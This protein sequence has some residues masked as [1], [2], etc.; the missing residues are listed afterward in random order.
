MTK[1]NFVGALNGHRNITTTA[2][3][4]AEPPKKKKKL[5]IVILKMRHERKIRKLEKAIRKLKKTPKQLKP[6]DEYALPPAVLKEIHIRTRKEEDPDSEFRKLS[7][8]WMTYRREEGRRER[9]CI[10]RVSAAKDQALQVLKMESLSL[11]EKA[12]D[13][14]H[15]LLPFQDNSVI[16]ETPLNPEYTPPDGVKTDISKIW[17]M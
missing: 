12:I 6:I 13:F 11:Y 2:V 9:D 1:V 10:I 3:L 5:D 14:D 17:A 16:T 8:I 7:K 4:M 15:K